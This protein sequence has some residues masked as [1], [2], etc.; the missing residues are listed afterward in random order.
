MDKR[1]LIGEVTTKKGNTLRFFYRDNL[2]V[3]ELVQ[4]QRVRSEI[5][6]MV[7]DEEKLL[8]HE[9]HANLDIGVCVSAA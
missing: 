3:V 5:I 9:E 8:K 2:L 7:L 6:R 1:D 4:N